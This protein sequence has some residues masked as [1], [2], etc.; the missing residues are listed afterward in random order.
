VDIQQ[1]TTHVGFRK[2]GKTNDAAVMIVLLV[3]R[4]AQMGYHWITAILDNATIHRDAMKAAVG[5]LLAE[6]AEANA[7]LPLS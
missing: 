6:I 7:S 5:E 1:G 3:L 2:E 4:Y